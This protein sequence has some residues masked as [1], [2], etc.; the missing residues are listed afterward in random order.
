MLKSDAY[1]G[2]RVIFGRPNGEKTLGEIV[3]V[4]L[5]TASVKTL[6]QRGTQRVSEA[7]KKWKVPFSLMTPAGNTVGAVPPME[8][9]RKPAPELGARVNLTSQEYLAGY[10]AGFEA[11]KKVGYQ[12]L[13][14]KL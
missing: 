14:S 1:K 5:S 4:N 10:K 7:G 3:S 2:M 13:A 12:E 11:G 6:E 8:L 9:L